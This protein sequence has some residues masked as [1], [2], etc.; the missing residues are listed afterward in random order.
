[1]R[2]WKT[3]AAGF[4]QFG[5]ILFREL[6][7]ALDSDPSTNLDVNLLMTSAAILWGLWSSRDWNVT[8]ENSGLK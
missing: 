4:A 1:M 6:G 2:N 8:S 3:T 7:Y 5:A